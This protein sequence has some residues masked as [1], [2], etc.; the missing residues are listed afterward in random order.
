MKV[1]ITLVGREAAAVYNGIIATKPDKVVFIFSVSTI[2]VMQRVRDEIDME[3]D[4]QKPLDP[5]NLI[6]IEQRARELAEKYAQDRITLNISGGTKSW[7][8]LFGR[9]FSTMP[10]AEV[11]YMDQ[12]NVLWNYT[13]MESG[14]LEEFDLFKQFRL[15]GNPLDHF[16]RF[17]EYTDADQ[18]A[19]EQIEDLWIDFPDEFTPLMSVLDRTRDNQLK[20]NKEG[21]FER[22]FSKVEWHKP[23]VPQNNGRIIISLIRKNGRGREVEIESPHAVD[24]AFNSGWMEYKIARVLNQ[25][26]RAR[27]IYLNSRFKFSSGKDKNEVDIIVGADSK[28]LFVECKTQVTNSIDIDKFRNVIKT[29][30]GTGS[31]GL[32]VTH[33]K[34]SDDVRKKCMEV[35]I[36]PFSWE[37]SHI[38]F[39][40]SRFK[41]MSPAD[42]L[43]YILDTEWLNINA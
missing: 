5:V 37:E 14:K 19:L 40:Q 26:G 4:E 35:G 33:S 30:G 17:E 18:D 2:E 31:K 24:I 12:N 20:N 29:Y 34:M 23:T 13:T 6:D 25:W 36:I 38:N 28:I 42:L 1:H 21:T 27:S 43:Y 32:F 3:V 22:G 41:K 16:T 10:N 8:F 7:A 9:V 11:V 39:T 15:Y